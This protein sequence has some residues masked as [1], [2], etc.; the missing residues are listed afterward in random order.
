MLFIKWFKDYAYNFISISE[1][2]NGAE[3]LEDLQKFI[4]KTKAEKIFQHKSKHGPFDVVEQ[5]LNVRGIEPNNL[6]RLC[7][8]AL[9]EEKEKA[10]KADKKILHKRFNKWITPFEKKGTFF[11]EGNFFENILSYE[12][13]LPS[14]NFMTSISYLS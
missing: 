2:V 5:I 7:K 14:K 6:E 12:K 8:V 4:A 9:K 3:T 1:R 10:A 11:F 13:C